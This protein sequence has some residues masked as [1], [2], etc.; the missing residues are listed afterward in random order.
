VPTLDTPENNSFVDAFK[1][2]YDRLP[3]EF[4]VQGYDAA[5]TLMAAVDSGA[6]DRASIAEALPKVSYTGPRGPLEIDPATN[7]VVQNIY[8]YETVAEGDGLTQ[9]IIDTVEAVRDQPEGCALQ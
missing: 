1:A 7:N 8:I 5:Q 6:S 3:S 2:K 9:K 4:A